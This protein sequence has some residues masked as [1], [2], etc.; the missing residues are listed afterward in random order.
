LRPIFFWNCHHQK[1]LAVFPKALVNNRGVIGTTL[2]LWYEK[3]RIY[4]QRNSDDEWNQ[5]DEVH[6]LFMRN[7]AQEN[8]QGDAYRTCD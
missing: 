7:P 8:H 5:A 4:E 2:Q 6:R 1:G 3:L